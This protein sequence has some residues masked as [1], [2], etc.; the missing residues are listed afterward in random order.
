MLIEKRTFI[1]AN[2]SQRSK[3]TKS[4]KTSDKAHI[5]INDSLKCESKNTKNNNDE[6]KNIPS[7]FQISFVSK[8]KSVRNHLNYAF[9][10]KDE[11]NDK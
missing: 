2:N 8:V 11:R 7:I 6:I 10:N 9:K 5:C 1:F 4:S 3:W